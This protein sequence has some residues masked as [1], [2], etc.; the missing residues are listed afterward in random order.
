MSDR[1]VRAHGFIGRN[2]IVHGNMDPRAPSTVRT[3][4]LIEAVHRGRASHDGILPVPELH[5]TA[6]PAGPEAALQRQRHAAGGWA[7]TGGCSSSRSATTRRCMRRTAIEVPKVGGGLDTIPVH[8]ATAHPQRA[9]GTTQVTTPQWQHFT[10]TGFYLQGHDEN[11][12]EWRAPSLR[13]LQ[14][15]RDVAADHR[16]APRRAT[17][18]SRSDR[19]S[20]G[21]TVMV[22]RI[23]RVK[24]EYQVAR[25]LFIGLV[26]QYMETDRLAA[27]RRRSARPSSSRR[28]DGMGPEAADNVF[29]PDV[30]VSYQPDPGT[31]ILAGYATDAQDTN[32]QPGPAFGFRDL[33]RSDDVI[34]V[35]LTWLF[36]M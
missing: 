26:G 25:P 17:T 15:G 12:S 11:F 21:S 8:R 10:F 22:G 23:P 13:L 34:F 4:G 29:H 2:G 6:G 36:R 14:L 5:R 1:F 28:S 35:K 18:G 24:V 7:M 27:G 33:T 31:M 32:P 30:L 3:G 19:P 16:T 9:S 20:D